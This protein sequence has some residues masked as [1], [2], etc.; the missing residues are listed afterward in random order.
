M[1][2]ISPA[3]PLTVPQASASRFVDSLQRGRQVCE[4]PRP[5]GRGVF[6]TMQERLQRSPDWLDALLE[7]AGM[8]ER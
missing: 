1:P 8:P 6:T 3:T 2:T 7:R 5:S 4:E